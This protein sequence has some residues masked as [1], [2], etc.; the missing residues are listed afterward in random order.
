MFSV[1]SKVVSWPY[2]WRD[3]KFVLALNVARKTD[4]HDGSVRN[5][6]S[7][8]SSPAPISCATGKAGR[9]GHTFCSEGPP[10]FSSS[11]IVLPPKCISFKKACRKSCKYADSI[12]IARMWHSFCKGPG[13]HAFSGVLHEKTYDHSFCRSLACVNRHGRR[14]EHATRDRQCRQCPIGAQEYR[15]QSRAGAWSTCSR[16]A[17][18]DGRRAYTRYIGVRRYGQMPATDHGSH[19][20]SQ[21]KSRNRQASRTDA[22]QEPSYQYQ[23]VLRGR[24]GYGI[25][26]IRHEWRF[27]SVA[28]TR[29]FR[30]LE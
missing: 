26:C 20:R 18:L 28:Y 11:F 14:S 9:T 15:R 24:S 17:G 4:W 19:E 22:F 27:Y 8:S 30:E 21:F 7:H 3:R 10:F 2:Q 5:N 25:H 29:H 1:P 13:S 23:Y 16:H 12:D 6:T